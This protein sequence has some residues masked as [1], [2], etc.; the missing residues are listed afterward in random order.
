[1]TE[2]TIVFISGFTAYEELYS[3][4]VFSTRENAEAAIAMAKKT[5]LFNHCTSEEWCGYWINE[6]QMDMV[7]DLGHPGKPMPLKGV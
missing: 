6:R 1:M 7:Y 5:H 4:G 3:F 2:P